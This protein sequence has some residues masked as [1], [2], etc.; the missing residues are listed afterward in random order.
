MNQSAAPRARAMA[1]SATTLAPQRGSDATKPARPSAS[2]YSSRASAANRMVAKTMVATATAMST[3]NQRLPCPR[4][5]SSSSVESALLP[6]RTATGPL[7]AATAAVIQPGNS[8]WNTPHDRG[9]Q[10][11]ANRAHISAGM[12]FSALARAS[13]SRSASIGSASDGSGAAVGARRKP[14]RRKPTKKVEHS[15]WAIVIQSGASVAMSPMRMLSS[16]RPL[17]RIQVATGTPAARKAEETAATATHTPTVREE[18]VAVVT[19]A[20]PHRAEIAGDRRQPCGEEQE[21]RRRPERS[22]RRGGRDVGRHG[23][24]EQRRP[25]ERRPDDPVLDLPAAAC[26]DAVGR[27][28]DAGAVGRDQQAGEREAG[29]YPARRLGDRTQ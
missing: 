29:R 24:R 15:R 21:L 8:P 19:P 14:R 3:E 9:R 4:A 2:R 10:I 12:T 7:T 25:A 13:H 11:A 18:S 22:L 5:A 16:A 20:A 1:M 23:D 27:E 28:V 17:P 26:R 6:P